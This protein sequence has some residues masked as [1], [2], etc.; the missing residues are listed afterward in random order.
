MVTL[1]L[2]V[3]DTQLVQALRD[4]Q[5]QATDLLMKRYGSYMERVLFR[6]LGP[7]P[8]RRDLL[9]DAVVE[10]LS[11][12]H[13]LKKPSALRSWIASTVVFTARNRL[14]KRRRWRFLR[15]VAPQELPEIDSE[16]PSIEA[17]AELRA[18]YQVLERLAP[19]L[20]IAFSLRF[21][22]GMALKD[23]AES[24]RVSLSTVK[25]RLAEAERQF[26]AE[27]SEVPEL[28]ERLARGRGEAP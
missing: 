6:I 23:I 20:R 19:D 10:V 4:G 21:V 28:A 22:E 9:H 12:L 15:F 2:E 13:R 26:V 16:E 18:T 8:E 27:A 25:R 1:P 17:S 24:C 3:T 5:P 11:S 14:R 7:D